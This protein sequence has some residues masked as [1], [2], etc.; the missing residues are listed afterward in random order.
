MNISPAPEGPQPPAK[1]PMRAYNAKILYS[2]S[3]GQVEKGYELFV[4]IRPLVPGPG[5]PRPTTA[6]PVVGRSPTAITVPDRPPTAIPIIDR[7]PTT[8]PRC[9]R[10]LSPSPET[11]RIPAADAADMKMP[12][13]QKIR[14]GV[15][16]TS[17]NS[18]GHI[19]DNDPEANTE[20]SDSSSSDNSEEGGNCE[21][22]GP[23]S[24]A[25]SPGYTSTTCSS[26]PS[27]LSYVESPVSEAPSDVPDDISEWSESSPV[28]E[29][30]PEG[31]DYGWSNIFTGTPEERRRLIQQLNELCERAE[32]DDAHES[33]HERL[34]DDQQTCPAEVSDMV[35]RALYSQ[36][37]RIRNGLNDRQERAKRLVEY[38]RDH[39]TCF[40]WTGK[41]YA[42]LKLMIQKFELECE[43]SLL[44]PPRRG[45][46]QPLTTRGYPVDSD[47]AGHG[48]PRK[49]LAETATCHKCSRVRQFPPGAVGVNRCLPCELN[50]NRQSDKPVSRRN[51]TTRY[52]KFRGC[53][54]KYPEDERKRKRRKSKSL[55]YRKR[56]KPFYDYR[57]AARNEEIPKMEVHSF[58][59][60]KRTRD[61]KTKPVSK[62]PRLE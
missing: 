22:L 61:V 38:L 59:G 9:I 2:T 53:P 30:Q 60:R 62:R 10:S 25:G 42:K 36:W 17:P 48:S 23:V 24:I 8:L 1:P 19:N 3:L 50:L 18:T 16:K 7:P 56:E 49:P 44:F 29:S 20:E 35:V 11:A 27:H 37:I 26:I 47:D 57:A 33:D 4:G 14:D 39:R 12:S 45:P 41:E 40:S 58:Y 32:K 28:K 43:D 51:V 52:Q 15:C 46:R 5:V 13:L 55:L 6:V 21:P 54:Y 31:D 34:G